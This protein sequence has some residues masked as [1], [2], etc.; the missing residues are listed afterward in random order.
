VFALIP[1]LNNSKIVGSVPSPMQQFEQMF[2]V[3]PSVSLNTPN[4]FVSAAAAAFDRLISH[5]PGGFSGS[6]PP[7]ECPVIT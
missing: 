7:I 6:S 4:G 2:A 1:S 5:I 3:W